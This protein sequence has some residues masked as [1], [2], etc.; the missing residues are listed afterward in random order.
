[1]PAG[2]DELDG[3][4]PAQEAF[5]AEAQPHCVIPDAIITCGGQH[6]LHN[7]ITTYHRP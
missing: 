6:A 2:Y 5:K 1:V 4:C 3:E 7:A